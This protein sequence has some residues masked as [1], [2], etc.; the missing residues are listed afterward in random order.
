MVRKIEF[1]Q[2]E[3]YVQ[4]FVCLN[5]L[6][7]CFCSSLNLGLPRVDLGAEEVLKCK[8][9][10]MCMSVIILSEVVAFFEAAV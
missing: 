2:D 3:S 6:I 5:G 1:G 4:V 9:L 8:L 7:L 10:N